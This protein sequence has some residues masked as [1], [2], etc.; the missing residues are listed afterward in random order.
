MDLCLSP[1]GASDSSPGREPWAASYQ[2]PA[3]WLAALVSLGFFYTTSTAE[4]PFFEPKE[5]YY[6]A[7]GPKITAEWTV[8]R[9]QVPEDGRLTATL[10]IRGATNP[11]EIVRPDLRTVRTQDK[12]TFADLFQIE[13][14]P[15]KTVGPDATEVAFVYVLRPR[16]RSV[17]RLP[18]LNFRY[19]SGARK[20]DPFQMTKARGIDIIV[21]AAAPKARPPAIPL[22]EPGYLFDAATGERLLESELYSPGL[23]A[24]LLLGAGVPAIAGVWYLV[25]QRI[26]PAAG[27]H[28]RARRSRAARRAT[29]AI[30]RSARTADPGGAVAS[31]V[32]GYLRSRFPLPTGAETPAEVGAG[33]QGAGL[34][35]KSAGE[36]VEFLRHC[37]AARFAP[38][39]DTP[40]TLVAA[41]ESLLTRLEAVV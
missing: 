30:R 4:P 18:T 21:T 23:V 20:G 35:A 16:N 6:K 17:N 25:W 2:R 38:A 19:D 26:D 7:R 40:P 14:T 15:Q 37:D 36:V 9:T 34:P 33:L 10:T 8:D 3:L 22:T 31:A 5:D 41:A 27:R 32:L 28:A 24:W 11:H 12:R 39:G 13:D 1:E 29:D